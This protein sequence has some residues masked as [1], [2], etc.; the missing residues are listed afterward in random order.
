MGRASTRLAQT[1]MTLLPELEEF[2]GDH[3]PH[4]GMTADATQPAWNGYLLTVA[5]PCGVTFER[6]GTPEQANGAGSTCSAELRKANGLERVTLLDK[7]LGP[8]LGISFDD[9]VNGLL[10]ALDA[11][12]HVPMPQWFLDKRALFESA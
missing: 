7:S 5:C 3:R 10:A 4:G 9:R 2:V 1:R 11:E 8:S 6:W 12:N